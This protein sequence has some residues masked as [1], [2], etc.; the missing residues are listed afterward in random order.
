MVKQSRSRAGQGF[1]R[2]PSAI[3]E[4]II[5]AAVPSGHGYWP[6]Q[7]ARLCCVS[8]LFEALAFDTLGQASVSVDN[9]SIETAPRR[10]WAL[11]LSSE[12]QDLGLSNFGTNLSSSVVAAMV[13]ALP[14]CV[15]LHTLQ[16][17]FRHQAPE[18]GAAVAR[19]TLLKRLS[20][21]GGTRADWLSVALPQLPN[22]AV[23]NLE[24]GLHDSLPTALL[25]SS[26]T[27][28][29]CGEGSQAPFS[30]LDLAS[31]VSRLEV[32]RGAWGEPA[33]AD[34][35]LSGLQELRL[36][37]FGGAN[38]VSAA[39]QTRLPRLLPATLRVLLLHCKW[40]AA[41]DLAAGLAGLTALT[42]LTL[43]ETELTAVLPALPDC[44]ALQWLSLEFASMD[45]SLASVAARVFPLC[46]ALTKLELDSR[47][48][49]VLDEHRL[50]P[51][52]AALNR[53]IGVRVLTFAAV[54][55]GQGAGTLVRCCE[56]VMGHP[57]MTRLVLSHDASADCRARCQVLCHA[58]MP[59]MELCFEWDADEYWD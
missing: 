8:R 51:I 4:M 46:T 38:L 31:R 7:Q 1:R 18:L 10:I 26:V 28:L 19:C 53:C 37:D 2:L 44:V 20:I 9:P 39:M 29:T 49:T 41:A 11:A 42:R 27:S 17:N 21:Y 47:D 57:S 6:T 56:A 58:R 14:L 12:L 3:V 5:R 16:I 22:L 32:N 15:A 52:F 24:I 54:Q 43:P 59:H 50:A 48:G 30:W 34:P 33:A 40:A 35:D 45:D 55:V 13:A 36:L 23:L 25:E